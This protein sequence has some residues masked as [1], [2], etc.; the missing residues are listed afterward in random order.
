MTAPK[1]FGLPIW[2]GK[3]KKRVAKKR[4]RRYR[5]QW[6]FDKRTQKE[7]AHL[8]VGDFINDC[9]NLN[10][11]IVNIFPTYRRIGI[12]RGSILLDVDFETHLGGNC[13][14]CHCGVE[15]KVSREEIERRS[16]EFSKAWA[17]DDSGE[18]GTA[19]YWFGEDTAS[20]EKA[21][22]YA[23]RLVAQIESGGHIVD[24]DGVLLK[25]WEKPR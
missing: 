10:R 15:P 24:E 4:L 5:H 2:K 18:P 12:G 17:L 14:L 8:G 13:S 21:V 16:L 9:S 11:K 23:K 25:E 20:Y 19:K 6:F 3:I 7:F 22:D 1:I